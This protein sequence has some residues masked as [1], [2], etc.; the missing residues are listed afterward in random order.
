VIHIAKWS[1]ESIKIA[2]C[3]WKRFAKSTEVHFAG[4]YHSDSS[5]PQLS[6]SAF[7]VIPM[8]P[9]RACQLQFSASTQGSG[10][11]GSPEKVNLMKIAERSGH[12]IDGDKFDLSG[13][14]PVSGLPSSAGGPL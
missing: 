9:S 3:G 4:V 7:V 13:S 1:F 12:W 10:V 5:E 11:F 6:T 8:H 14:P 2:T